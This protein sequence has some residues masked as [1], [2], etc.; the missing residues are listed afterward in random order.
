MRLLSKD[1]DLNYLSS[2]FENISFHMFVS[3]DPL[4]FISC[5][6]C[7]CNAPD[8]VTS[9]WHAIQSL[10]SVYNKPSN[11]LAAWNLYLVFITAYSV[12]VWDK[13]EM[14]N[15]KFVAR[16]VIIDGLQ[17]IPSLNEIA[18]ELQKQLL[19]S[20]LSLDPIASESREFE[21]NLKDYIR[22]APLDSKTESKEKRAL[23]INN[24]IE[25]LQKNEN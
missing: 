15:N 17:E 22:G 4:S 7:I 19:G 16:K 14:E 21:L 13:Y 3:D 23:M 24:I 1:V 12:P 6:A 2:E 10:L 11:D 18:I 8:D 20:D 25:F 5:I 9:N